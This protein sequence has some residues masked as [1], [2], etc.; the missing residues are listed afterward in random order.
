MPERFA[1]IVLAQTMAERWWD[2]TY[3]FHIVGLEMTITSHDF[4]CM[5]G[6]W[7][8]GIL[9][10]L[11]EEVCYWGNLQYWSWGRFD[12][13]STRDSWGMPSDGQSLSAILVKGVPVRQWQADSVLEVVG[14]FLR[15]WEGSGCQLRDNMLGLLLLFLGYSQ[16]RGHY[17]CWLG[18]GSSLW[19]V[20]L[21]LSCSSCT[22]I[23]VIMYSYV[24]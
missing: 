19:L 21:S 18:L 8:D 10:S 17:A 11:K 12:A 16:P 5:I 13:S 9:I 1:N 2:S 4:H 24:I 14:P 23:L 20:S 22:H 15:L 6:L 7:F 3:T